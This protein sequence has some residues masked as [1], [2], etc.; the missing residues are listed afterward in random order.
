MSTDSGS[1]KQAALKQALVALRKLRADKTALEAKRTEPIAIIG[2]ACRFPGGANTPEAYWDLLKAGTDAIVEV[3]RSRFDIDAYYD[4]NP[5][6][7]G[8]TITRWGGFIDDVDMFDA[9]FFGISPRE[10]TAMDPQQRLL[11]ETSWEAFEDAGR[12]VDLQ[13]SNTGVFVGVALTDYEKRTL[14]HPDADQIGAYAGTG[15]FNSVAGGRIS[16]ALGLQG[17]NISIDTACSTT[18]VTLHLAAQSLRTG[19][20]DMALAGGVNLLISPEAFVYFSQL[21][22][23]AADGR[24]KTFDASADGYTR[25]EGV[26]TVVLKRLSDAQRDGDRIHAVIAGTAINQDGRSNGLTAPSGRA[27][28]AVINA[29][30][31]NAGLKPEDV[32]FVEAHGTG[33]PLGDPI[34]FEALKATYG[35]APADQPMLLGSAKTNVGHLEACAGMAGLLKVVLQLKH[36]QIPP[37]L[38]LSEL[39]PRIS[40]DGT[41]FGIPAVLTPWTDRKAAGISSFGMS[42]TNAHVIVAAAPAV[43]QAEPE[44]SEAPRFVRSHHLLTLSARTDEALAAQAQKWTRRI[45]SGGDLAELAHTANLKRTAFEKRL[46]LVADS[47]GTAMTELGDF[48]SGESVGG[49]LLG[50]PGRGRPKRVFLFTGQGSQFANMGNELYESHPVFCDAVDHCDQ[51]LRPIMGCSIRE[52]LRGDHPDYNIDDTTYTQPALF[53]V[54]YALYALWT[55]W[56]LKADAV[57]G[58]SIGELV[59]AVVAGVMSLEDGLRLV[60]ERGRLM[61]S[62]PAG[63]AMAA[64]FAEEADVAVWLEPYADRASIA[65]LN[66][67]GV[68]VISGAEGAVAAICAR[69]GVRTSRLTVS[70]AF[71]SPLMEPILDDFEKLASTF[72]LSKPRIPMASNVTG[73]LETDLFTTAKYWRDHIRSAVRF[74]DNVG[75]LH[76]AGFNTF[77][78]LGPQATLCGLGRRCIADSSVA[79]LPSMK[80]GLGDWATILRS[81]GALWTRGHRVDFSAL[82]APFKLEHTDAPT[83]SW[84]HERFWID[85]PTEAA[86][87][88][89]RAAGTTYALTW[90][91]AVVPT[92][93]PTGR[94]LVLA[95]EGGLGVQIASDLDAVVVTVGPDTDVAAEVDAAG[96]LAG[97]IATFGADLVDPADAVGDLGWLSEKTGAWLSLC[98][99]MAR[100]DSGRLWLVTSGAVSTDEV[101]VSSAT[102]AGLWG[103]ARVYAQ[104]HPSV[105]GGAIDLVGDAGAVAGLLGG[106]PGRDWALHNGVVLGAHLRRT[107]VKTPAAVHA[108]DTWLITGGYGALGLHLAEYLASRGAKHLWLMGRR[109][110]PDSASE[111]VA[112][113]EGAGVSVHEA[114]GDVS[115]PADVARVLGGI[116]GLGGVIH[117]AGVLDDGMLISLD[118]ASFQ[119]VMGAKVGGAFNLHA[120]LPDSVGAFLLFSS[121]TSVM[122]TVGQAN[123]GAANA[124]LD[125]LA[126][127]RRAAGAAAVS[128]AWGPWAEGGMASSAGLKAALSAQGVNL[129]STLA[130][131][132]VIDAAIHGELDP[133]ITVIDADWDTFVR[134]HQAPRMVALLDGLAAPAAAP[135][136][137]TVRTIPTAAPAQQDRAWLVA[138][139][140]AGAADVLGYSDP[141]RIETDKGFFDMGLDSVMA[142]ALVQQLQDALDVALPGTLTFDHPTVDSLVDHLYAEVLGWTAIADQVELVVTKADFDEPIAI[143]GMACRF[144]GGANDPESFWDLLLAGTDAIGPIPG[145]RWNQDLW[146]DATP[147]TPGK[148]YV[149]EG[150]FVTGVEDFEPA[151]FGISPREARSL[152]PQQRLLLETSWEALERAAIAPDSVAQ[153]TTGVFVGIGQSDYWRRFDPT[154]PDVA[155]DLGY[156]GTGNESSFAAG[157]VAY[158]LGTNGPAVGLNTACSTSLVT[159]HLACQALRSRDCDLALAGGVHLLLSP[160]STVSISQLEALAPDGRCKTFDESANGYARGEG[161]GMIVLKRL[162]DAVAAGD[163]IVAVIRGSAVNHD[164]PSAGLT[165]PSGTAQRKLLG[166]ALSRSGVTPEQVGY[167]EAHGTGTRLGDPIELSAV[168]AVYGARGVDKPLHIGSVKT[169]IGHLELAAGV[170]GLM[171]AALA[172]EKATIP[173]HLHLSTLNSKIA[174][175]FPMDIPVETT[176]WDSDDRY[177]AVSSFGLSGTNA[178]LVLGPAPARPVPEGTTPSR[179]VIPLSART[180]SGL[181][182]LANAYADR[183][184]GADDHDLADVAYTA[185]VGRARLGHRGAVVAH[186]ADVAVSALRGLSGSDARKNATVAFLFTGQGSQYVG[187]GRVAYDTWPVFASAFDRVSGVLSPLL[188]VSLSKVIFDGEEGEFGPLVDDTN[189]T[190]PALFAIQIALAELVRS[191]GVTPD[192]VLGHSVGEYAAAVV[193]GVMSEA[194]GAAL[195]AARG[196]LMAAL[197]RDGAMAAVFADEATVAAALAPYADTVSVAALNGASETVISGAISSVDAVLSALDASGVKSKRLTVSHAF[198]SPLMEPMLDAFEAEAAKLTLRVPSIPVASNVTGQFEKEAL[199]EPGYW[200]RHVRGAVRF[201][202]GVKALPANAVCIEIGPQPVLSAMASRIGAGEGLFLPTLRRKRNDEQ[203]V[204]DGLGKAWAAGVNV[205]WVGVFAG[206]AVQTTLAPTTQ[207]QRDRHWVDRKEPAALGS[208]VRTDLVYVQTWTQVSPPKD[209]KRLNRWLMVGGGGFGDALCAALEEWGDAVLRSSTV[210]D[211]LTEID[212]V[213]YLGALDRQDMEATDQRVATGGALDAALLAANAGR[214][215]WFVTSGV[216]AVDGHEPLDSV[217]QAPLWGLGRVLALE[218]PDSWGGAVDMDPSGSSANEVAQWLRGHSVEDQVALRGDDA[219]APR[220]RLEARSA[221]DFVVPDNGTVWITGGL[222]SLGLQV[223]RW[224]A[225]QGIARV[226]LSS[227]RGLRDAVQA[228]VDALRE[229]VDVVVAKGDVANPD[230]VARILSEIAADGPPLKGVVHAAGVLDDAALVN[231]SWAHFDK[232]FAAKVSGAWNLHEAT[233]D[234]DLAFFVLFSSAASALGSPGQANYAA[235][236]AFLDALADHRVR[237]QLPALS[238]DWGPWAAGGMADDVAVKAQMQRLGVTAIHPRAGMDVLGHLMGGERSQALV[239]DVDWSRYRDFYRTSRE[240]THLDLLPN[241]EL[242]SSTVGLLDELTGMPAGQATKRAQTVVREVAAGV[243]GYADPTHMPVDV[244]FFELGMDSLMAVTLAQSVESRTGVKS[245]GTLAFDH[246]TVDAVADWITGQLG[247]AAAVVPRLMAPVAFNEPIAIVGMACRFPGG[248]NNLASYWKLLN[249]GVD[250]IGPIPADRWPVDAFYDPEQGKPGHMYVREGGFIDNPGDF[251]PALFGISPREAQTMDP[252][253]RLLVEVA[254]EALDHAGIAPD[255]L[256]DQAT[257]VFVGIGGHDYERLLEN[258]DGGAMDD[259]QYAGTGNDAAFAAGRVSYVLGVHG[260]ALSVN[261]ACSSSLVTTHLACQSLRSGECDMAIAGGVRLMLSPEETIQLSLLG[262]LSP[263]ARCKTFDAEANGY[264]RGEGCGMIVLKRLSDALVSGDRVLAVVEGSAVNHDGPSSGLTVPNGPAQRDLIAHAVHTAGLAPAD[265]GFLEAHGTGTPLGD[266]IEMNAVKGALGDRSEDNPLVVGAVKSNIGH[267]ELA[268]GV[269]GIIK[270]V[271]SLNEEIIPPNLHYSVP[272]PQLPMD[273]PVVFPTKPTPWKRGERRRVAGISAFGLSGTNAHLVIAEAP[274]TVIASSDV[275][276]RPKHLLVVTGHTEAALDQAVSEAVIRLRSGVNLA[277]AAH[278]ANTGRAR[279]AHRTAVVAA[280]AEEAAK[281]LEGTDLRGHVRPGQAPP[282]VAMLFTGQGSQYPD[283]GRELYEGH[284]VFRAAVDECDSILEALIGRSI[285]EVMYGGVVDDNDIPLIHDTAFTQPG[286]FAVEYAMAR[287]WAQWGVEPDA[288]VGHSV[289]EYVAAVIAGV[290]SLADGLQIIAARGRLMSDLPRDGSMAAV[291]ATEATVRPYVEAHPDDVS[292]A[293]INNPHETV[294]SGRTEAVKQVLAAL[295]ADGH[296]HKSL[297]VSHAFHSPCMD[298]MLAEFEAVVGSVPRSRPTLP[299]VSNLTGKVETDRLTDPAYWSAHIRGAVRFADGLET[300]NAMGIATFIEVGPAP[301]LLG[302]GR[303]MLANPDAVWLPSMRRTSDDW[304]CVLQSVGEA[305]VAGVP[306]D[307]AALDAPW[308]RLVVD[309]PTTPFQHKR[310]WAEGAVVRVPRSVTDRLHLTMT[311]E[312]IEPP[313]LGTQTPGTWVVFV[314]QAGVGEH[315]SGRLEALGHTVVRVSRGTE[316]PDGGHAIDHASNSEPFEWVF[317]DVAGSHDRPVGVVFAWGLDG[318]GGT[319]LSRIEAGNQLGSRTLLYL[320]QGM[321]RVWGGDA[322]GIRMLTRNGVNTFEPGVV[323]DPTQAGMWGFGRCLALEQADAWGAAIDLDD[324]ADLDLVLGSVIDVGED[325]VAI[326]GDRRLGAR[327][328]RSKVSSGGRLPVGGTILITGGL[329]ALGRRTAAWLVAR[330]ATSLVL[331][332]R[333]K[334]GREAVE[335]IRALEAAGARVRVM[336][337]D[338]SDPKD[339]ARIVGEI[340]GLTGVIHAAGVLRDAALLRTD[341]DAFDAVLGAKL[342]GT[343]HLLAATAEHDLAMFVAFSSAAVDTGSPGQA[344]YAAANA[345]MDALIHNAR[346]AGRNAVSVAFGPI[347]GGGMAAGVAATLAARGIAVLDPSVA[348]NAMGELITT[349]TDRGIVADADWRRYRVGFDAQRPRPLLAELIGSESHSTDPSQ[350]VAPAQV[351]AARE[352]LVSTIQAAPAGQRKAMLATAVSREVAGVLGF[353]SA[354]E[355]DPGQGFFDIGMDSLMAV[356]LLSRLQKKLDTGLPPSLAFDYPTVDRLTDFLFDDVLELGSNKAETVVIRGSVDEPIAIV[357]MGCRY[358]G[359]NSVASFWHL[360]DHGVDASGEVPVDRWDI[361]QWFDPTPGTPGRMY[362]KRASFLDQIDRFDPQFFGISPRE[363]LAMDPQQ[364]LL[365]EVS[366]EALEDADIAATSIMDSQTGVYVGIGA[367]E[368]DVRFQT[369]RSGSE[370]ALQFKDTYSGTGNDSSFAAGRVAY[371]LGLHG[372]TLAVNTACSSS[373]VTVHLAA[374]ALRTGECD[375]ALAGGVNLMVVPDSTVRLSQLNALSPDGRCKTFDASADGYAR[376]EGCGMVVLKRLSEAVANGDRIYAVLRGSAVNHDGPSSGLT[377]PNGPAQQALIRRALAVAGVKPDQVGYVEAHG[378]GTKLGDPIELRAL[379]AV[380]G[381]RSEPL[382]VGSVKTNMGHLELAAGVVGLMKAVLALHHESVPPHLHLKQLNPEI[383]ADMPITIPTKPTPWRRSERARFAGVSSFGL[384]GTNAHLVLEEAPM[385]AARAAADQ[386]VERPLHLIP[387]SGARDSAVAALA[388]DYSAA[389]D[390]V[391]LPDLAYTAGVGRN[392]HPSRAAVIAADLGQARERLGALTLGSPKAGVITG[393]AGVHR[394]QVAFLFTGQGSQ[395]AGMSA[396]LYAHNPVFASVVDQ[397]DAILTPLLGR[398]IRQIILEDPDGL[399]DRTEWTQPA[400]FVVEVAA[401]AMWAGWG[402][403]P[404]AVLGHSIGELAAAHVAGIL[405]L[406]DALTLVAE[407]GRL[408]GGLPEGGAMVALLGP[409]AAVA[410]LLD[411]HADVSV[412][413]ANGPSNTVISGDADAV[414]AITAA[415]AAAGIEGKALTVSHAFHSPLMDPILDAFGTVASGVSYNQ[416]TIHIQVTGGDGDITT[417]SYWRDQIRATVRFQSGMEQLAAAGFT[418]FLEM[419]PN[420]VLCGMGRRCVEDGTWLSTSRRGR[421]FNPALSAVGELYVR[422]ADI[423]WAGFDVPYSRARVDLPTYPFQRK[424]YWV[425][426][427]DGGDGARPGPAKPQRHVRTTAA[428]EWF[429]KTDWQEIDPPVV[430]GATGSWLVVADQGGV[431]AELC[432][433]LGAE[434]AKATVVTPAELGDLPDDCVGVVCLTGLDVQ[435]ARETTVETLIEDRGVVNTTLEVIQQLKGQE[436]VRLWIVTRGAAGD[437]VEALAAA[438]LWGLGRVAA[439]EHPELMP[440]NVDL[441]PP[442]GGI[443]KLVRLLLGNSADDRFRVRDGKVAVARWTVDAPGTE[444]VRV[445]PAGAYLITGGLGGLGLRVGEWL[446]EAGATRIVLFSRREPSGET[447]EHVQA[448]RARGATVDVASVDV[449]QRDQ[450]DA[451]IAG[452]DVPVAGV[453][454]AAGVLD[455]GLLT[456]QTPERFAGVMAAKVEGTWNLHEATLTQTPSMFVLF[457]S[458]SSVLGAVGQGNYAAGNAFLDAMAAWRQSQG[459]SGL[460]VS[461]GPWAEVGMAAGLVSQ[462]AQRGLTGLPPLAGLDA[463]ARLVGAGV[464]H[465][466]VID[467]DLARVARLDARFREMPLLADLLEHTEADDEVIVAGGVE[468]L[469]LL[470]ELSSVDASERPALLTAGLTRLCAGILQTDAG[471]LDVSR[472]LA[473]QGFDSIMAVDL[474]KLLDSDLGI[475]VPHG[476]VVTGPSITELT[477]V[478]GELLDLPDKGTRARRRPTLVPTTQAATAEVTVPGEWH[479][480]LSQAGPSDRAEMLTS[481]LRDMVATLLGADLDDVD[482]SRPLAW[483][484]FDSV[485]ATDFKQQLDKTYGIDAPHAELVTG[486]SLNEL[487]E[488]ILPLI[489]L[490]SRST[491]TAAHATAAPPDDIMDWR[492]PVSAVPHHEAA[493]ALVASGY[494]GSTL[495]RPVRDVLT[496]LL[497]AIVLGGL[498]YWT[499]LWDPTADAAV[500]DDRPADQVRTKSKKKK[501]E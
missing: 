247:D 375:L 100:G 4:P 114:K 344:S 182:A 468:P 440:A 118:W 40:F 309:W 483:Q 453:F 209:A 369:G 130:A 441:P 323:V 271:L 269:A 395:Y 159:T 239:L 327:L 109:G 49:V 270:L 407:R 316:A 349:A 421:G 249:D 86:R 331:T 486:P 144:P 302:M 250:A 56:G 479:A 274:A 328:V 436:G 423:D 87:K 364:R 117:A 341:W 357:G 350:E 463:L 280:D 336:T 211:S 417:A 178:H 12:T 68:T 404:D 365:L 151:M 57:A 66:S 431:A 39:N 193:A 177:A 59:A 244:G 67:P 359:A 222:G 382:M 81:V 229:I 230:D 189:Y 312:P 488:V 475:D 21:G 64:V 140:R 108:A 147:A 32:G 24:C 346:Q 90:E 370:Q 390:H 347:A 132:A 254:W 98:Q 203:M 337:G 354:A 455:D 192:V 19:E 162:S 58:H 372:P 35:K 36:E 115:N 287:L 191:W 137:G 435:S 471:E 6:T 164:G 376:G 30:L 135:G 416:P 377:V 459:L 385:A 225:N 242:V 157:R 150:G 53:V 293:S 329:G 314:D 362:V 296:K 44:S 373:L 60:A 26:A 156:A 11:L 401:A 41:R 266:P 326:R 447:L 223:A 215:V 127:K 273:W 366:W 63:G 303:R 152:D 476:D 23:M 383:P 311:W 22:A 297:T 212:R 268:A 267:L 412:A 136:V 179:V 82:D 29:A 14:Y 333:S 97:V 110:Q 265:I 397:C 473:W 256:K 438:P 278:T 340:E 494:D 310:Y 427:P 449:T 190:Q 409:Y 141:D 388:A 454:H 448:M 492:P 321:S 360:L 95:D 200:R 345:A 495:P 7:P 322:P 319:K 489:D 408:M 119:T 50:S 96:N 481:Q 284:P 120:A 426:L 13:G 42:G 434:G 291:F 324:E 232:V 102:Q 204:L 113:L 69:E 394:P 233:K 288:V 460:S 484:G 439:L 226:V 237:H 28:K 3:P 128:L 195:V 2:M 72:A 47:N 218:H 428:A 89:T 103:L 352:G 355:V 1:N 275:R 461:W 307:L 342:R 31:K 154:D 501:A 5:E 419:G 208:T 251:D 380:M 393:Q 400:L 73:K 294:V 168:G 186:S 246:P 214:P 478:V 71:H 169:N 111:A 405:S 107:E 285:V 386:A 78:E 176:E 299:L 432:L 290:F 367:S 402:V 27:Q 286:L 308:N 99:R 379:N 219:F 138:L 125:G 148:M 84:R 335:D 170:A 403:V 51:L 145:N 281:R 112:L 187:M 65:A 418:T 172:I 61:G 153:S 295:A 123:Y 197:P 458:V 253:Q 500:D 445:D 37:H 371:V 433:A 317:R 52:V 9:E 482:V 16:Y 175:N 411:G 134:R 338:V 485:M 188:E 396:D 306:V 272:N 262:A 185:A 277:H 224:L 298:P 456:G 194:D 292:V 255:Q 126:H 101:P 46:A 406:G 315:I 465:S 243:L 353:A 245:P 201:I 399:I 76:A 497:G 424:R 493:H 167:L 80:R 146:F 174:K 15:M 490:E 457:G 472:P 62:L 263:D 217:G 464:A 422:G 313:Y 124:I 48:A 88:G 180:A 75:A 259:D 85:D 91:P 420:P 234:V 499:D 276:E 413:A 77:V 261:T 442:G 227:R 343:Y 339:V 487:S 173:A 122:G 462:M 43:E 105:W 133:Q 384:N 282:Q 430:G 452:L 381:D 131:D 283:M 368:Y 79:W 18:L 70:H 74:A 25:G 8:K 398:S 166:T 289:G 378:T 55:S 149:R 260:P 235:A 392:H 437:D 207:W 387:L 45:A 300:L 279:L 257:G 121:A 139:V 238:V 477:L 451:L 467:V 142:V 410:P 258:S 374:Q 391:S 264:V 361:D 248:A 184:E 183:L 83:Y 33:T 318:A 231:Q 160:E 236:N 143:V 116:D 334:P 466:A 240:R 155:A 498:L 450:I 356:A 320:V 470:D 491:A 104:E 301:I 17:P 330:G 480:L 363:A 196:R 348:L 358:P 474:K 202:D 414:A 38:H 158:V 415:A 10:A 106:E 206:Q 325:Q 94:W 54:E 429:F 92:K 389:L 34:E 181:A 446:A 241:I 304:G 220:I 221:H 425:D 213:V 210:P 469:S 129:L 443:D 161:C 252:Q 163:R 496:F 444:R 93:T 332:S 305:V 171:K 216:H 228:E 165:V 351:T 199:T 198:H 205:D 20:S